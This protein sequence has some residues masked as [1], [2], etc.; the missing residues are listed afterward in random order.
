MDT[1]MMAF[2]PIRD[3]PGVPSKSIS[4]WSTSRWSSASW[5]RIAS[6]NSSSLRLSTARVT[7]LPPYSLPPSRSSTAS[8]APVDAPLGT[9]ARPKDPSSRTTST[10]RVGFPRES[11]ICLACT[12]SMD[13]TVS[14]PCYERVLGSDMEPSRALAGR[15]NGHAVGGRVPGP[16]TGGEQDEQESGVGVRSLA[17][18]DA[19]QS[20]REPE[21]QSEHGGHDQRGF[22][23]RLHEDADGDEG[24]G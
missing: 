8:N 15:H 24:A 10:S 17:G 22:D 21:V 6:R 18:E 16:V 5:P 19:A 1:P 13:A 11:R 2:A 12:A 20:F 4:A 9:P 7:P 14:A 23:S 3:L